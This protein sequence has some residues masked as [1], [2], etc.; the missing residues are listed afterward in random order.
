MY[1]QSTDANTRAWAIFALG[2]IGLGATASLPTVEAAAK[3][4]SDLV[5][6]SAVEALGMIAQGSDAKGAIQALTNAI[7]RN[8]NEQVRFQACL[9]L[10][11]V[12]RTHG[13]AIAADDAMKKVVMSTLEVALDDSNRY[14]RGYAVN[15]MR[16]LPFEEAQ[17]LL[18]KELMRSRWDPLTTKNTQF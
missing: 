15:V 10:A 16:N 13:K 14:V 9:S 4:K 6:K 3:D 1:K 11:Q 18:I 7:S 12:A 17:E 5:C 8:A 2:E